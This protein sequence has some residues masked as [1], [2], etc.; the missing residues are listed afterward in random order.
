MNGRLAFPHAPDGSDAQRPAPEPAR[1]AMA[2]AVALGRPGEAVAHRPAR[3]AARGRRHGFHR[4][5]VV[6]HS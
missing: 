5:S 4:M 6:S 2:G 3:A 1:G